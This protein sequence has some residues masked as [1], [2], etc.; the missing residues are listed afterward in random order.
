MQLSERMVALEEEAVHSSVEL[1][2]VVNVEK[3]LVCMV[4]DEVDNPIGEQEIFRIGVH[5]VSLGTLRGSGRRE[6]RVSIRRL[7]IV[8][9]EGTLTGFQ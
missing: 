8:S 2:G 9:P 1:S 7:A 5:E 3:V 4:D 6:Q